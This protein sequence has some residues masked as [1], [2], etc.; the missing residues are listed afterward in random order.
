MPAATPAKRVLADTTKNRANVQA[1]PRSAKR[2]KLENTGY[3][4]A[5]AI[6][7]SFASS[8][9]KSQFEEDVLEKLSQD[10]TNL[11]QTNTEKD[12]QWARPPLG[13]FDEKKENLCFQQIEVE[14]GVLSGGK[15]A[16]KLFGVTEVSFR[17][18]N[19]PISANDLSPARSLR[20]FARHRLSALLLRRRACRLR[21]KRC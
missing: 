6:N 12:Q 11:K 8:Q 10:L 5:K 7:G 18:A 19:S 20:P 13:D 16:I 9:P 14:E 4:P 1:S 21:P 2:P 15:I 3:G 17:T